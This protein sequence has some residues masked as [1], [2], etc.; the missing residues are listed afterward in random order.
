MSYLVQFASNG[1][2]PGKNSITIVDQTFN[3]SSLSLTLT[4]RGVTNY[5]N[6][7]Q[8][9]YVNILENWANSTAPANPT[10]GQLWYNSTNSLGTTVG[11]L[12]LYN[13]N[14]A[15]SQ[16]FPLNVGNY[17]NLIT[18]SGTT[19]L[20][21]NNLGSAV[22]FTGSSAISLTLPQSST[23]F[24][25]GDIFI[26]N[27]SSVSQTI[28]T[29]SGD[30]FSNPSS[31]TLILAP[32]DYVLVLCNVST[33]T[34]D[35]LGSATLKFQPNT[36]VNALTATGNITTDGSFI[37][38]A[39][40]LGSTAGNQLIYSTYTSTDTD[41]DSLIISNTRSLAGST[42][43][44]AGTRLQEYVDTT[45]MGWIQFNNGST[46][47]NNGGISF[48]AG[49]S[50]TSAV[51]VTEK[52]RLDQFGRLML[53][54]TTSAAST[55]YPSIT[56]NG[57]I[58][59]PTATYGLSIV[60]SAGS[61]GGFVIT[62]PAGTTNWLSINNTGGATFNNSVTAT[63]FIGALSGN[64]TT[65][66]SATSATTATTATNAHNLILGT[67]GSDMAFNWVAPG[68]V[69]TYLWGASADTESYLY[70]PTALSGASQAV[71]SGS[72][73]G[74]ASVSFTL[75]NTSKVSVFAT[76]TV[77]DS[78]G[79]GSTTVGATLY[80]SGTGISGST[81]I[82]STNN[83]Q[84]SGGWWVSIPVISLN[85]LGAGT[86]TATV[87]ASGIAFSYSTIIVSWSVS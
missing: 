7:Q 1:A 68:G 37:V 12:Q 84:T 33:P 40:A 76:G 23:G 60:P 2:L 4:G 70:Q 5:G 53:G 30:T 18:L 52:M 16:I 44:S 87:E 80:M 61:S 55:S 39:G 45:W 73:N 83:S 71:W 8:N 32:G 35:A 42:W 81:Q 69:P 74:N 57:T 51:S 10:I 85:T 24:L 21:A 72:Y 6:I 56:L 82:S 67:S 48:G 86:F 9:N 3:S 34:W 62:N 65:A 54:A 28:T 36:Y 31:T 77:E 46:T 58:V 25:G 27:E 14:Q 29:Y 63:T 79:G 22:K 20:T 13:T 75:S 64:A 38:N 59:G 41:T 11:S 50:S 15:W 43:T 78:T 66:T 19:A 17:T 47:T 26:Y 49:Q